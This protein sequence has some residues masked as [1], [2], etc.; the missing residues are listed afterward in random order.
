MDCVTQK[1]ARNYW[2]NCKCVFSAAAAVKHNCK[3]AKHFQVSYSK[4]FIGKG[5]NRA[6][7][8]V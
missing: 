5:I 1:D 4:L 7:D 8:S 2:R 3:E 6:A